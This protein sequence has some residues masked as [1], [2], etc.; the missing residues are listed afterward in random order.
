MQIDTLAAI[1]IGSNAIRLLI[2]NVECESTEPSFKKDAF[3]RVPVRLGEDVF[4][5]GKIGSKKKTQLFDAMNGFK[6][7]MQAYNV[8]K[9]RACAT[10]AMR[11][12]ENGKEIIQQIKKETG[13]HVEIINGQEEANILFEA[14]GLEQLL[15]ED[16]NYLYVDVGGGSTELVLFY[17]QQKRLSL[18][19]QIGTVRML[20]NAVKNNELIYFEQCLDEIY[21]KYSPVAIIGSGG[22]I[23]KVHKMLGKRK[24]EIIKPLELEILHQTLSKMSYEERIKNYN[25]NT[26]RADVIIPA[27]EIFRIVCQRCK[28]KEILVPKIGI[29]DGI[30]HQ[31][32]KKMFGA[33]N[34]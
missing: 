11:D 1:D 8:T 10:S 9:Y 25:L 16:K 4:T 7:I 3:L 33:D 30:I 26:Y 34:M 29:V 28:V 5:K 21:Q 27:L 22:N 2:N 15:S 23:N 32:S 20:A 31:L 6:H 19:F 12:A 14:G 13:I 17:K 18:S 24:N